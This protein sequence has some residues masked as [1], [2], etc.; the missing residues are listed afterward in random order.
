MYFTL[1]SSDGE[2]KKILFSDLIVT[3]MNAL[4]KL[5]SKWKVKWNTKF[6]YKLIWP[7]IF[8][9]EQL[10]WDYPIQK[11]PEKCYNPLCEVCLFA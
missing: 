9:F 5:I 8:D 4:K 7:R 6:Q 2:N 11:Y 10:F 1:Y 3:M